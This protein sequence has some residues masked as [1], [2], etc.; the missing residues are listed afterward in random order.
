MFG[1]GVRTAPEL[2]ARRKA[3][4]STGKWT[5][6]TAV[7]FFP[8]LAQ[9]YLPT[10]LPSSVTEQAVDRGQCPANMFPATTMDP[11]NCP[12]DSAKQTIHV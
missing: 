10:Y 4:P 11:L 9:P 12:R 6:R 5:W 7:V 2:D 1:V 8:L 3:K